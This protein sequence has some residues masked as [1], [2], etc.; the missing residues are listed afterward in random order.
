MVRSPL[1]VA[2]DG[3]GCLLLPPLFGLYGVWVWGL[4]S[5]SGF[6]S[7]RFGPACGPGSQSPSP[8]CWG[9]GLW[10]MAV[11][12]SSCAHGSW[13]SGCRVSPLDATRPGVA[14]ADDDVRFVLFAASAP[15]RLGWCL[16]VSGRTLAA[17][18]VS[19]GRAPPGCS[20]GGCRRASWIV[21]LALPARGASLPGQRLV[22]SH[23]AGSVLSLP[24][25]PW[26]RWSGQQD[27]V[28]GGG[29]HASGACDANVGCVTWVGDAD[30]G[31]NGRGRP[32]R[33][34]GVFKGRQHGGLGHIHLA[35]EHCGRLVSH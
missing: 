5:S 17:S 33:D 10:S 21:L 29:S 3:A 34:Q 24:V 8:L 14:W 32:I 15:L 11:V 7:P 35:L 12:L 1:R 13:L 20:L 31:R 23:P 30:S 19:V 9:G 28:L 16:L 25:R 2:A 18:R 22:R 4:A 27:G 6:T 26:M